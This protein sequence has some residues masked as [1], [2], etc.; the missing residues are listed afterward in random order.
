[1]KNG[2]ITIIGDGTVGSSLAFSLL[3]ESFLSE[4]A[5][6]DY[7][8][9]KAEGDVLD[10]AQGLPFVTPKIIKVGDYKDVLDSHVVVITAGVSQKEGETRIE[11]L[12]RNLLVFDSII[13]SLRPFIH[14]H[15]IV[16]VV[17]NPVDIL[18][19]YT[20]KKLPLPAKQIIGS[21]TVLDTARLKSLLAEE[22]DI[23]SRNIHT[24]VLGEHG[25][26]E[27]SGFSVTSIG[28]LSIE[29]FCNKCRNCKGEECEHL[30]QIHNS[31][32][33]AAYEIINKKGATYYAVALA[34]TKILKTIIGNT[35]SIL[36]V[37]SLVNFPNYD[38]ENKLYFS[39]P[40][41]VNKDG[42]REVLK[43]RYSKKEADS[44]TSSFEKLKQ[45]ID[46]LNI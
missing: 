24:Y 7:N 31:V 41:I 11:L 3:K 8:K 18:T 9:Q 30:K 16:L 19:Y 26:S 29:S 4:I 17:S 25:D 44:I 10:L 43:L 35:N 2:K 21:G 13:N 6:I 34:V 14:E 46:E 23:D 36:T 5:I 37:S 27:V 33:N 12:K 45:I 22:Y 40:A 38:D 1:M 32:K 39:L 28:G 20:Y 42:V 15:L